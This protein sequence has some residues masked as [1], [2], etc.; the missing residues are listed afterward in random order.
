MGASEREI[1]VIHT[2]KHISGAA[3]GY[4]YV[5]RRLCESLPSERVN[6][7]VATLNINPGWV[8]LSFEYC[9]DMRGVLR[10]IGGSPDMRAWLADQAK[11]RSVDLFHTHSLWTMANIYPG[12][13]SRSAHVPLVLSPHGTLSKVAW[14]A[15]SRLKSLAWTVLQS[16][17][18]S[19]CA[20]VHVTSISEAEDVRRRGLKAPIAVIP[21]GVD[22]PSQIVG[23]RSVR[24]RTLLYLGRIHRIK[25]L[26]I[27]LRAWAAVEA[28]YP[29]WVLR[30]V[31]PDDGGALSELTQLVQ[32]LQIRR[33]EFPGPAFG[34]GKVNE[35]YGAD[36]FVLPSR[37]ENFGVS[38][39]EAL[40]YAKPVITTTA[41]PWGG[42]ESH[43]VGWWVEPSVRGLIEGLEKALSK[44][45]DELEL[46]GRG[47]RQWM[48]KDFSWSAVAAKMAHTYR[49]ILGG[50]ATPEWIIND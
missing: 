11:V 31:G 38:I 29:D 30:I 22:V 46:M 48:L 40:A 47:G 13:I 19:S 42:V 21:V 39:A 4:A 33:V 43:G 6:A 41:A 45:P 23:E 26:D 49:W 3:S 27:L 37:S 12:F 14:E 10:R 5:I 17:A 7:V 20:C 18:V 8:P 2:V 36:L 50:G 28:R 9:F 24:Q 1:N 25:G 32:S 16:P 34:E 44:S 35:F 15:G